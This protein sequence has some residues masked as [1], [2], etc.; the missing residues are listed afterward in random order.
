M[1][2][3]KGAVEDGWGPGGP[4]DFAGIARRSV[5]GAEPIARKAALCALH[6]DPSVREPFIAALAAMP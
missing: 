2:D 1:H 5:G 3:L 6:C 4:L